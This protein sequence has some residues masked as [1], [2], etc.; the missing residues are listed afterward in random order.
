MYTYIYIYVICIYLYV[1]LTFIITCL[2]GVLLSVRFVFNVIVM[3]YILY[4]NVINLI[5]LFSQSIS[6]N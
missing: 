3:N 5:N 2:F 4:V 1:K 6:E